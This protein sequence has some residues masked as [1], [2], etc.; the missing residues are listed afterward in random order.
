MS[1]CMTICV[2]TCNLRVCVCLCT[3]HTGI[4]TVID[5]LTSTPWRFCALPQQHS[6]REYAEVPS[7]PAERI[8]H[9]NKL[10]NKLESLNIVSTI[11]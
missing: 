10:I 8:A 4:N 7:N 9:K 6:L 2:Y 11:L 1:D 5:N 3:S